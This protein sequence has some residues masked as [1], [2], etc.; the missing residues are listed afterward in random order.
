MKKTLKRLALRLVLAL[1]ILT[2]LLFLLRQPIATALIEHRVKARTGNKTE[3]SRVQLNFLKPALSAEGVKLYNSES[4]G[5]SLFIHIPHLYVAWD[6]QSL[7]NKKLRLRELVLDLEELH[8][9]ETES[10][11]KNTDALKD[12]SLDGGYE[13]DRIDRLD[14][15][16]GRLRQTNLERPADSKLV[17][18]GLQNEILTDVDSLTDLTGVALKA[19]L[20]S[21]LNLL[22][23]P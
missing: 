14:L 8:I 18:V 19:I 22:G 13:F 2:A 21:G 17:R 5:D 10:G 15:S 12:R 20:K 11:E 1:I 7:R 16:L 23:G 3:I 6:R 4:F 9:V